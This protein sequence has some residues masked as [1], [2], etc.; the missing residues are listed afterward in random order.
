MTTFSPRAPISYQ[1]LQGNYFLDSRNSISLPLRP[2]TFIPKGTPE[3]MRHVGILYSGKRTRDPRESSLLQW[4]SGSGKAELPS[5]GAACPPIME[6]T[7]GYLMTPVTGWICN[8]Q[9]KLSKAIAKFQ[10]PLTYLAG[11]LRL[12]FNLC[13]SYNLGSMFGDESTHKA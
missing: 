7:A 6:T 10:R 1:L 5:G 2:K 3:M 11:A 13:F 9:G 8:W 12:H 4:P